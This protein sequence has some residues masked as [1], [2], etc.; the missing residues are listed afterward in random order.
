MTSEK[1]MT[2]AA[3]INNNVIE[4][5]SGQGGAMGC[6]I[7]II[8]ENYGNQVPEAS[9]G[10]LADSDRACLEDN[11]LSCRLRI[12]GPASQLIDSEMS[13]MENCG[14]TAAS[15]CSSFGQYAQAM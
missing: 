4:V 14:Q 8:P 2:R 11:D 3:I 1:C 9:K 5:L 6:T 12:D 10:Q 13:H 15:I 7:K